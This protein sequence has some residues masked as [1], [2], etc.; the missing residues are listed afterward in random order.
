MNGKDCKS[1]NNSMSRKNGEMIDRET[2][3]RDA[4]VCEKDAPIVGCAG[5]HFISENRIDPFMKAGEPDADA[6]IEF[7]TQFNEFINH[8]P[9]LFRKI[10]DC[11]MRL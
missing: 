2:V 4:P 1:D 3:E 5:A 9:R 8:E 7:V 10:V 6:Y 11:R